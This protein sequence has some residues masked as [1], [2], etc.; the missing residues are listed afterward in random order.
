IRRLLPRRP[1]GL[2]GGEAQRVALGRALSFRPRVLLLDEPLS[3]LDEE[4]REEMYEL[5]RR[6]RV[7]TGATV[8]HVTHNQRDVDALGDRVFALEDG[9]I[10]ERSQEKEAS[11][12]TEDKD[13]RG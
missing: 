12:A 7:S 13:S 10:V 6:V 4:T 11:S 5:L 2:S 1:A 3:A 9:R 8:L